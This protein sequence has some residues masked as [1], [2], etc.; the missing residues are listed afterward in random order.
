MAWG[1]GG[2]QIVIVDELNLVVVV[3]S[4]PLI[5]QHGGGPW[6]REKQNLNL[7]GDFIASLAGG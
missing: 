7:V 2:Q 4:D 3:K 6:K 1:H 5:R